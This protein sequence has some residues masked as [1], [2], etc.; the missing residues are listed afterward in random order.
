MWSIGPPFALGAFICTCFLGI[1]EM[2]LFLAMRLLLLELKR[3]ME[4][5][6]CY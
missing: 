4:A 3:G 1:N 6:D 2:N 5:H